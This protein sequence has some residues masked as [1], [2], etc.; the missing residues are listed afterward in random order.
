MTQGALFSM[1]VSACR[2]LH[3]TNV[4]FNEVF[5]DRRVEVDKDAEKS[6]AMKASDFAHNYETILAEPNVIGCRI[7]VKT[8][9]D[10][11]K[12][13]YKPKLSL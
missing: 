11:T 5:L 12:L 8:Y 4:R 6:G 10:L 9:E 13:N 2:E 3:G 7:H 1:S